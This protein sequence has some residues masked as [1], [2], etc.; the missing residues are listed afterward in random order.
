[1]T[2]SLSRLASRAAFWSVNVAVVAVVYIGLVEPVAG[3]FAAQAEEIEQRSDLLARYEQ[4]LAGPRPGADRSVPAG[5]F[6]AGATDAVRSA[7]MQ[8]AV[9]RVAAA[10][11]VRIL[12]VS[13]LPMARERSGVV[14]LRV[15]MA[16]PLKGVSQAIARLEN[17]TPMLAIAR[18]AIRASATREETA[19]ELTPLDVQID[20]VGF[21]AL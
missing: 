11:G 19:G 7:A 17:G 4:A 5:V 20:I 9:K 16:G 12:S 8:E 21:G 18:T 10:T 6:V 1:M 15:D 14:A 3:W 13:A 2:S